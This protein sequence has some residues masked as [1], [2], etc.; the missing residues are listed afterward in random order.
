MPYIKD[1]YIREEL[2]NGKS[3]SNAGEL[4]YQIFYFIKNSFLGTQIFVGE[5]KIKEYIDNF[6]G[7]EPNYQ[8]YNDITG[9]LIRCE[10]ELE[11]RFGFC[12][13]NLT[14]IMESYDKEIGDYETK[15][16]IENSDVE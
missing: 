13:I 1:K 8:R 12:P 16:C 7:Q 9:A 5:Q 4:N 6:L 11:R 10:K 3:A 15:K 14:K 2:R